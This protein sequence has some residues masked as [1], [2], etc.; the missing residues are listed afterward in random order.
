MMAMAAHSKRPSLGAQFANLIQDLCALADTYFYAGHLDTAVQILDGGVQLTNQRAVLPD[1]RMILLLKQGRFLAM[2]GRHSMRGFAP[3]EAINQQ[4][5]DFAETTHDPAHLAG[6]ADLTGLIHYYKVLDDDEPD[7]SLPSKYFQEGLALR[8]SLPNPDPH[9]LAESQGYFQQSYD[10]TKAH[11]LPYDQ[12]SAARHLGY[13]YQVAGDLEAARHY[14]AEVI[15]LYDEIGF[16]IFL[17]YGLI[18]LAEL[19]L[20][21]DELDAAR[22]HFE[23]AYTVATELQMQRVVLAASMALGSL[24]EK[25]QAWA[26]AKTHYEN[27]LALAKTSGVETSIRAALDALTGLPQPNPTP[28]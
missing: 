6:A 5:T 19:Y 28:Q 10:L 13:V 17:P 21:Q 27:A 3:A 9:G 23:R 15:T 20:Q 8:K 2:H 22:P 4:V 11:Q 16:K 18:T 25:Q 26:A 14:Y 24:H 12:A 1:D 7:F